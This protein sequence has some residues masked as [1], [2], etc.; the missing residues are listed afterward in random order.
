MFASVNAVLSHVR[1]DWLTHGSLYS[2]VSQSVQTQSNV[3][4]DQYS[5]AGPVCLPSFQ[6]DS[7]PCFI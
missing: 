2:G 1:S 3:V 4:K 6:T 5:T 7:A